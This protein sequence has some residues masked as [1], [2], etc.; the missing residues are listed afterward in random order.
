MENKNYDVEQVYNDFWKDIV[1]NEDGTLDKE[2]VKKELCDFSMIME[3]CTS[4]Y[5]LASGYIISK[6]NTMFSEVQSLFNE[7]FIDLAIVKDDIN[8]FLQDDYTCEEFKNFILD[9][10]NIDK[11]DK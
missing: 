6:P 8:E 4:A 11:E 7:K 5:M 3:N 2:Q 1:E 9:Y 10:F